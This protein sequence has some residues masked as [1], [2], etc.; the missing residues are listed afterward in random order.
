MK[1]ATLAH[2]DSRMLSAAIDKCKERGRKARSLD[3]MGSCADNGA[4]VIE[5]DERDRYAVGVHL[6]SDLAVRPSGGRSD[7]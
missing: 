7:G 3:D 6:L 5:S 4:G 1:G 2:D